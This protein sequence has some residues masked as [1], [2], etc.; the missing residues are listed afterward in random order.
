MGA[1][2][3]D[4]IPQYVDPLLRAQQAW[5]ELLGSGILNTDKQTYNL[6]LTVLAL[7]AT[8]MKA[9]V[10]KGLITDAEWQQRLNAVPQS[11]QAWP[12]WILKQLPPP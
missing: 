2:V 7:V 12:D 8:I 6:N 5:G 10:D 9:M 3:A 4:R 11:D 1:V